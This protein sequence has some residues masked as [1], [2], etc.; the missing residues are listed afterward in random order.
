MPRLRQVPSKGL[1]ID[2][3]AEH[4]PALVVLGDV[5][6]RHPAA[7]ICDLEQEVDD[8]TGRYQHGVL[9]DEVRLNRSVA[10]QDQEAACPVDVEGVVHRMV[11]LHLVDEPDLHPVADPESASR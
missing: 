6:V 2:V 7:G 4:H 5:A 11:G 8:L 3:E 10:A 9:P 1:G